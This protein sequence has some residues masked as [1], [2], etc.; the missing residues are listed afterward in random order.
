MD[1]E[2]SKCDWNAFFDTCF[3]DSFWSLKAN[4]TLLR[5]EFRDDTYHSNI[6]MQTLRDLHTMQWAYSPVFFD[7]TNSSRGEDV[8][9]TVD[10][11]STDCVSK[12]NT[13]HSNPKWDAIQNLLI[14]DGVANA[15]IFMRLF[16]RYTFF[17]KGVSPNMTKRGVRHFVDENTDILT[18][19]PG[20]SRLKGTNKLMPICVL[21]AAFCVAKANETHVKRIAGYLREICTGKF[22]RYE[23][24]AIVRLRNIIMNCNMRSDDLFWMAL[25]AF[26]CEINDFDFWHNFIRDH[27]RRR[28]ARVY[29]L[30]Y[31]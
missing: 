30:H 4:L 5:K 8:S 9:T 1:N 25:E 24:G 13:K 10:N 7:A 18:A 31:S 12:Q 3:K 28:L 23:R 20:Y 29:K 17:A 19:L 15:S 27:E 16:M 11:V 14:A 26:D 6:I 22:K 21:T 2:N